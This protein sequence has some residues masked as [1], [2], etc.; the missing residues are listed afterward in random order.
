MTANHTANN[1]RIPQM[2]LANGASR[3]SRHTSYVEHSMPDLLTQRVDQIACGYTDCRK[4][5]FL[6]IRGGTRGPD[7]RK[8]R[9]KAAPINLN[10]ASLS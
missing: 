7:V 10:Q 8:K 9:L 3:D 4:R 1:H 6:T 2:T 5:T